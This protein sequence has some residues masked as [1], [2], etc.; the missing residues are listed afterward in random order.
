[1]R[2]AKRGRKLSATTHPDAYAQHSDK[3]KSTLA[4]PRLWLLPLLPFGSD[5][6][7]QELPPGKLSASRRCSKLPGRGRSQGAV[8]QLLQ[9][10]TS[11]ELRFA[12]SHLAL[13]A[14]ATPREH[15]YAQLVRA[16]YAVD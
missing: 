4:P 7:A 15:L 6:T 3:L 5:L 11:D 2:E 14:P 12:L 16:A 9:G 8:Q 1:M 13:D 10:E